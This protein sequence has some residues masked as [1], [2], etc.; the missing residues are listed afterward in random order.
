MP[1]KLA[2]PKACV[3]A[4]AVF[5]DILYKHVSG[6]PQK[7][8]S[9]GAYDCRKPAQSP[10]FADLFLWQETLGGIIQVA[11][12]GIILWDV[13]HKAVLQVLEQTPTSDPHLKD[14]GHATL[15]SAEAI[16]TGVKT[17]LYHLRRLRREERRLQQASL[18]LSTEDF[19]I[20]KTMVE[21]IQLSEQSPGKMEDP[22]E[23]SSDVEIVGPA[24]S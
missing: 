9:V 3:V 5:V 20:L 8:L 22:A 1:A 4:M 2:R 10:S 16:A 13:L 12:T 14:K 15:T 18:K 11:P 19:A 24:S 17:M 23:S 21:Q 6:S 7:N